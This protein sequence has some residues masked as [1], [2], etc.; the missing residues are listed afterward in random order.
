MSGSKSSTSNSLGQRLQGQPLNKDRQKPGWRTMK[1]ISEGGGGQ[2]HQKKKC[3]CKF[4]VI[5]API[6]PSWGN[7]VCLQREVK[8]FFSGDELA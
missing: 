8:L 1:V 4:A 5:R 7:R 6:F 3:T 2:M